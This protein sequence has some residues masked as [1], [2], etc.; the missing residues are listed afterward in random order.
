MTASNVRCFIVSASA[1][2]SVTS[3]SKKSIFLPVIVR[4][5]SSTAGF[6]L[7]KLSS[8]VTSCPASTRATEVWLPMYPVPPVSK[9]LILF[10]GKSGVSTTRIE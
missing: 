2:G 7:A 1:V 9:I 10:L 3:A 5:L 4:S 6:E 8:R